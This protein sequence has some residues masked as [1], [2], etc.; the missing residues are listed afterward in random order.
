MS[1]RD[2]HPSSR[3]SGC[4]PSATTQTARSRAVR[5]GSVTST[6][7][8]SRHQLST[9]YSRSWESAEHVH[10]EGGLDDLTAGS[11][12]CRRGWGG[13]GRST[14][15]LV[16][17]W[18]SIATPHGWAR[19]CSRS[20]WLTCASGREVCSGVARGACRARHGTPQ[21]RRAGRH[22]DTP[23]APGRIT[24]LQPHPRQS[25]GYPR[26]WGTIPVGAGSRLIRVVNGQRR[27]DHSRRGRGA[28]SGWPG[29]PH[30]VAAC[31]LAV[32]CTGAFVDHRGPDSGSLLQVYCSWGACDPELVQPGAPFVSHACQASSS[33]VAR[34]RGPPSGRPRAA[35]VEDS[36]AR[37]RCSDHSS[38]TTTMTGI[39]MATVPSATPARARRRLAP[40]SLRIR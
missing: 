31:C 28:L 30:C 33:S 7:R 11:A 38:H 34:R 18:P 29:A 35:N 9:G 1:D 37:H 15:I 36:V 2:P 40:S 19:R 24:P 12:H 21:V 17:L 3:T 8:L 26:A 6:S 32:L 20:W 23:R 25:A 4:G 13:P 14:V 22:V 16:E 10:P 5:E 27:R 39:A